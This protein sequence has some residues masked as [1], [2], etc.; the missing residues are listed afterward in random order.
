MCNKS[1]WV[2]IFLSARV[3]HLSSCAG[4]S[5]GAIE[6]AGNSGWRIAGTTQVFGHPPARSKCDVGPS[7]VAVFSTVS[8]S[9]FLWMPFVAVFSGLGCIVGSALQK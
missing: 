7:L 8:L 2:D 5:A 3:Y 6:S 9:V 4:L 1:I